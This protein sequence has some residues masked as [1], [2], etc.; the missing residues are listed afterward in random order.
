MTSCNSLQSVKEL[1]SDQGAMLTVRGSYK[2]M[3]RS[4]EAAFL[5]SNSPTHLLQTYSFFKSPL[6]GIL[7]FS[8]KLQHPPKCTLPASSPFSLPCPPPWLALVTKAV[9][10]RPLAPS[11]SALPDTS[12]RARSLT[13]S[14]FAT[15]VASSAPVKARVVRF[16]FPA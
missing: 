16:S 5:H 15:T 9:F 13:L 2:K 7:S 3:K 6:T 4:L 14:G 12:R 11:P 1:R 10:P 8:H